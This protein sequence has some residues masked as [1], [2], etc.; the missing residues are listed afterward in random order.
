MSEAADLIT[1][2]RSMDASAKEDCEALLDVLADNGVEAELVDDQAPGVPEG[3]FEIRVPAP[4]A[5]RAEQLIAE[6]AQTDGT[7]PVD[8]SPSL[9]L[10]TIFEASGASA[11]MQ[12]LGVQSLLES[13]GIDAV[14][15][16]D[17]VLPNL[18]FGVKVARVNAGSA[19]QI[20]A[21]AQQTGDGADAEAAE[22]PR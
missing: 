18:P 7:A 19:R 20:I 9:D 8:P 11:E 22:S 15:V 13:N 5:A 17:S 3:A 4:Q 10:E 12:A 2:Y 21:E 14:L 6:D 16:G 1:V